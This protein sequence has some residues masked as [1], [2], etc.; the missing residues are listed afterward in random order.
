MNAS[1]NP[2]EFA[3]LPMETEQE[4]QIFKQKLSA[5]LTEMMAAINQLE[6]A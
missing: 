4:K 1:V 2:K 5:L 6:A 3:S